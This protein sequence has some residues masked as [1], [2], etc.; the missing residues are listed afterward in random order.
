MTEYLRALV[1]AA[2]GQPV[3]TR[4]EQTAAGPRASSS[5]TRNSY[6]RIKFRTSFKNV[7][8]DVLVSRGY[9]EYGATDESPPETA[10]RN[11]SSEGRENDVAGLG[12]F[13]KEWVSEVFDKVY[14]GRRQRVN[15]FRNHYQ[16]TRKDMLAKNLQRA[17]EKS[18][19]NDDDEL[20]KILSAGCIPDTYVDH[21]GDKAANNNSNSGNAGLPPGVV[22]AYV[23][24]KYIARPLL[25]GGKKFDL[26][27][28]VLVPNFS[29]LTVWVYRQG[30]A[31]LSMSRYSKTKKSME[32]HAVHLTN[33]AVQKVSPGYNSA[34]GG[35][36]DSN[37]LKI[38]L[39]AKFGSD[40][41]ENMFFDVE[42]I[43]LASLKAVEAKVAPDKHSFELYGY[44]IILDEKLKPWLLEVNASPS[45]TANTAG[46]YRMKFDL[47]DDVFNVLNIEGII[48][49]D[50]YPGLR[51]IGGFDLLYR[52]DIGRVREP[53]PALTKSRLARYNDRLGALRELAFRIAARDGC[54]R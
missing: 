37:E 5:S 18:D 30:F 14:L 33:V 45:L 10:P 54:K 19:T 12:G 7:I 8:Y 27:L 47:L 3:G 52:S 51:Q 50:L 16:L 38:F 2:K 34:H 29:P 36:Y 17:R 46:D 48:P 41:V 23:V 28:Y 20:A 26:R 24:Q 22:E 42:S 1:F 32:N 53:Y 21:P 9:E 35:K 39:S 13:D 44:D 49:E 25:L 15:H 31:R 43:I 4:P 40:R 6:R 11:R